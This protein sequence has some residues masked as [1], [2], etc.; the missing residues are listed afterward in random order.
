MSPPP[1]SADSASSKARPQADSRPL[2][3]GLS[4][5]MVLVVGMSISVLLSAVS[6][7][8]W[9]PWHD[10]ESGPRFGLLQL[11]G[12]D[13]EGGFPAWFSSGLLLACA[14]SL[15]TV[16]EGV[17][18]SGER[19][20]WPWLLLAV[21]FTYLS[22][23]EAVALHEQAIDPVQSALDLG[24]PFFYGWVVVAIP[25][26]VVL[27]VVLLPFL[28]SLEPWT[29]RAFLVAGALYVGGALGLEMVEGLIAEA[30]G[31]GSTAMQIAVTVEEL[32]EMVG[33]TIFLAAV[34]EHRRRY[35][36]RAHLLAVAPPG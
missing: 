30:G 2:W 29:R 5:R 33:L 13:R 9:L 10:V 8:I 14:A 16:A 20:H 7:A 35:V 31:R 32:L 24:G 18:R 19:R 17:R 15:G 1:E 6:L 27:G 26:V 21:A 25:A 28:R 23:D 34:N 11:T 3:L 22:M 36:E 4:P 12:V